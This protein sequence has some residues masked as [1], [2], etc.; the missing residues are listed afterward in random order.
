MTS[1]TRSGLI[2]GTALI[3]AVVFVLLVAANFYIDYVGSELRSR[4]RTGEDLVGW[5]GTTNT[6][7]DSLQPYLAIFK[8]NCAS[9]HKLTEGRSTGPGLILAGLRWEYDRDELTAFIRMG[10]KRYLESNGK[11]SQRIHQLIE[12][13]VTIMP[14]QQISEYDARGLAELICRLN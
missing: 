6:L 5:C 3:T 13:Y 8:A 11:F 1:D 14:P 9:C 10:A 4:N 7:P 2:A 12:E